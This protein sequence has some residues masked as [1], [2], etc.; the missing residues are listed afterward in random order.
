MREIIF[1]AKRIDNKEWLY[2]SLVCRVKKDAEGCKTDECEIFDSPYRR[3]VD[4]ET[5]GEFTG[6][7]D[8]DGNKI[9]GGDIIKSRDYHGKRFGYVDYPEGHS[10]WFLCGIDAFSDEYL[11][12]QSETEII[13]NIFDNP[14]LLAVPHENN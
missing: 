13:G 4:P 12:N 8:R 6:M 9:F 2:G 3:Y 5:V 7:F 1:R 14:E 10:A 11:L